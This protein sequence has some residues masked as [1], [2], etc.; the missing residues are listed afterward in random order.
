MD[1]KEIKREILKINNYLKECL[2]MDFEI[3]RMDGN[4]I[5]VSGRIDR[6]Y[7]DFAIDIDFG[8][9]YF[10]S[11]LMYWELNDTKPFISLVKGKNEEYFIDKYRVEEGNYIFQINAE[12]FENPPILIISNE[13]HC[14]ILDSKPFGDS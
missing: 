7:N 10:V 4:H 8:M 9:P 1:S 5:L 14:K 3:V 13:I 2:W 12:D 11:S 6:S